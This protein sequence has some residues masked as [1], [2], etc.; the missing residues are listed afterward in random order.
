MRPLAVAGAFAAAAFCAV[1]GVVP[2]HAAPGEW[3]AIAYD[4]DGRTFPP[5][6]PLTAWVN[7]AATKAD[8]VNGALGQICTAPGMG[9]SSAPCQLL[10]L[11]QNGCVALLSLD[12]VE[13]PAGGTGPTI[14][15]AI[16]S[17]AA[18]KRVNEVTYADC[19]Y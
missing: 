6:P 13:N 14:E 10:A 11:V 4:P 5:S 12:G 19:T 16:A 1:S 9:G 15:A 8:A 18:G 17:T 3:A 2:A 7:H